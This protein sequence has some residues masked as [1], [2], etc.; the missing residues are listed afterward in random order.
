M[1][2]NLGSFTRKGL[3]VHHMLPADTWEGQS[4]ERAEG[5]I[6]EMRRRRWIDHQPV[7]DG[8]VVSPLTQLHH[9]RFQ[10]S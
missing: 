2:L 5:A 7:I 4:M 9:E 10:I 6:P 1:V 3:L 8:E